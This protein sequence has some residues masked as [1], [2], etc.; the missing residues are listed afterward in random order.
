MSKLGQIALDTQQ[1]FSKLHLIETEEF[2]ELLI[3]Q[4]QLTHKGVIGLEFTSLLPET[5]NPKVVAEFS[6]NYWF[7]RGRCSAH[8]TV[9]QDLGTYRQN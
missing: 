8:Q 9:Q 7:L 3:V 6:P 4:G 5:V 1:H 2:P